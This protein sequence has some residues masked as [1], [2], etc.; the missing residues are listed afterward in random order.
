MSTSL[1]KLQTTTSL[2]QSKNNLTFNV[3]NSSCLATNATT[4]TTTAASSSSIE[5]ASPLEIVDKLKYELLLRDKELDK[6]DRII[7]KEKQEK[8]TLKEE[9]DYLKSLIKSSTTLSTS[10]T[11]SQHTTLLSP[12]QSVSNS[13]N[14]NNNDYARRRMHSTF[15]SSYIDPSDSQI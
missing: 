10:A 11:P 8:L 13:G 3:K 6:K 14:I 12:R 9:N 7:C 5:N 4:T 15:Q 2:Q 1:N